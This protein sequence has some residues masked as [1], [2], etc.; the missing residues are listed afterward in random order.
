[1]KT[2]A[3]KTLPLK[4]FPKELFISRESDQ[5]NSYFLT[6]ESL[7]EI[8]EEQI[9]GVYKLVGVKKLKISKTLTLED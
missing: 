8:G 9:I 5:D 6:N 1:M 2:K 7:E 4:P 3:R